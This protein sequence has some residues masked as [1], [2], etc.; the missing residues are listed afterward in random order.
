[1]SAIVEKMAIKIKTS[2]WKKATLIVTVI[3]FGNIESNKS[4]HH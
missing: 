4:Q 2:Y 3:Y 1:M